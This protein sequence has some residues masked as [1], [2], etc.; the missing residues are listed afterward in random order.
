MTQLCDEVG[1]CVDELLARVGPRIVLGLPIGIGKPVALVNELYRR[2]R[3]DPALSLTIITGLTLSRPRASSALQRR[4]LQPFVERVFADAPE[5][6]YLPAQRE[7]TLPANVQVLEFFFEPGTALDQPLRQQQHLCTNYTQVARVLLARGVNV[8]AQ[9]VASRSPRGVR[10]LSLGGNPDITVDL[11]PAIEA[12]RGSDRRILLVGQVHPRMPFMLGHAVVDAQRFDLLLEHDRY[13]HELFCP[14]NLPIGP[15]DHAIGLQASA[16]LRDGGTL[17]LG[18]G[19]LGDAIV[20]GL[21]LRHQQNDAWRSALAELGAERSA[22]LIDAVG[23]RDGFTQGLFG[24]SE[25]FVDQ[26]LDLHRG[27]ILRRRVFDLLP[28]ER[29]LASGRLGE[30]FG[31]DVLDLLREAGLPTRIDAALFAQLQ[32]CGVFVAETRFADG[33]IG[34]PEGEWIS[35]D[36]ADDSAR[37]RLAATCLGRHLQGGV[38]LQAGFLLGPKGFYAA[39][40]ELSDKDRALFDLRGVGYINQLDGDDRELRVLQRRDARFINS[41][42]MVTLGGAAVSDGL[43][44]G[45]VVSGVG[46]QHDFVRMAQVLPGARS[47]LCLRATRESGGRVSSNIIYGYGHVTIPRQLRDIVITEYGCADLAGRTD[48]EVIAALL[49]IADSRF[50]GA[51]LREAQRHGKIAADYCIP[52]AYRDNTPRRLAAGFA[53]S[54][55]LGLFSEFPFGTDFSQEEIVLMRAL[56]DLASRMSRP[57]RAALTVLRAALRLRDAGQAPYL[58]RMGLAKSRG[59]TQWLQRQ[60][61]RDALARVDE[62]A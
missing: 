19:E 44:D 43:A 49:N 30:R 40:R 34:S 7:G 24:C 25:L 20:Y 59:P 21:Q 36:L 37:S 14:P 51:L 9:L 16:L 23:G 8:I 1:G 27:G 45:R 3:K 50:Q 55:S 39:L 10:E 17:Q 42:M 32:R 5:L 29:L 62:D 61:L 18:I 46:G 56:K 15:V 12:A 48:S 13:D 57:G 47:I 2:A 22:A 58:E 52:D 35:A 33:R 28:L 60:L 53:R 26:L 54:R 31:P 41:T 4:F 38:V 6:D 11:L